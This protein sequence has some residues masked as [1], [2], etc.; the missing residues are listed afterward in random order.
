M[1]LVEDP[2]GVIHIK[3]SYA[4][5][6]VGATRANFECNHGYYAVVAATKRYLTCI[7]CLTGK[8]RDCEGNSVP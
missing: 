4:T 7:F 1:T 3:A 6:S 5:S 8:C 2:D